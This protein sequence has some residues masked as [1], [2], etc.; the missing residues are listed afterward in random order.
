LEI[1]DHSISPGIELDIDLQSGI[2]KDL[3]SGKV[4]QSAKM[5]KVMIDILEAGGL[6]SYLSK[7]GDYKL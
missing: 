6:V 4:Y 1:A 3:A 7:Y 5:P 2:V